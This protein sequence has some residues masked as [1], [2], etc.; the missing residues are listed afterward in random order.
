MFGYTLLKKSTTNEIKCI[1]DEGDKSLTDL[2]HR[3]HELLPE[4]M[5][6]DQHDLDEFIGTALL[7]FQRIDRLLKTNDVNDQWP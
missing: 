3:L 2:I 1:C 5:D 7:D 6:S 4:Y